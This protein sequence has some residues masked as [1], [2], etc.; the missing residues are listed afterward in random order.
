[1]IEASV[2]LH[3][4]SH[5]VQDFHSSTCG[6]WLFASLLLQNSVSCFFKASRRESLDCFKSLHLFSRAWLGQILSSIVSL[7]MSSKSVDFRTLI[8]SAKSHNFC[9]I[10]NLIKGLASM[11]LTRFPHSVLIKEN[12]PASWALNTTT[13]IGT[14]LYNVEMFIRVDFSKLHLRWSQF[15]PVM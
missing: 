4:A 9:Y 15:I 10:S 13:V 2:S 5:D 8:T 11:I 14:S 12:T 3:K 1:M 6:C 7:F